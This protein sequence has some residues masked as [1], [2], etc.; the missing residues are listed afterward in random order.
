MVERV[1]EMA[2][3]RIFSTVFKPINLNLARKRFVN[4][5]DGAVLV[6]SLVL[7]I[8]MVMMGGFA[9]DLMRYETTRTTLQNTLDRSTLAAASLSQSLDPE[10]VMRD[11]FTKAG[12]AEYLTTVNV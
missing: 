7:F 3:K 1:M 4:D 8:L 6:F 5:E 12:M 10:A 2:V 11:Y 9:V